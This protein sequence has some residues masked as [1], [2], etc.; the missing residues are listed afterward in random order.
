MKLNKKINCLDASIEVS[1]TLL[2]KSISSAARSAEYKAVYRHPSYRLI[3]V[4][5]IALVILSAGCKSVCSKTEVFYA[6]PAVNIKIDGKLSEPAWKH[7]SYVHFN[8][9]MPR[10]PRR[11]Q[12]D[13]EIKGAF[14]WNEK[15]LYVG[16]SAEDKDIQANK[17]KDND[18]IWLEDVCEVFLVSN[19]DG[20]VPHLEL[21]ISANG[22][23]F[24]EYFIGARETIRSL[25]K[26]GSIPKYQIGVYVDGTLNE[27]KTKDR[28]WS[29]EWFFSWKEL[30][31]TGLLKTGYVIKP[32]Q[33]VTYSR[34]ANWNIDIY[35]FTRVLR[36]T[37]PGNL[38]PHFVKN[39]RPVILSK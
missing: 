9:Y 34:L 7:A 8:S 35:T 10:S 22:T 18:W 2:Q 31:R 3:F 37:S 20:S 38:V 24:E 36:Y 1:R 30:Q 4:A 16:I 6:K 12:L 28:K 19:R 32:G 33:I 11:S 25:K 14:L 39:Y 17:T 23:K 13:N 21:Q 27:S 29:A 5:S 15:G 26:P